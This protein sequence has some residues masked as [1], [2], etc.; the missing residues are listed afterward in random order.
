MA[1]S[2]VQEVPNPEGGAEEGEQKVTPWEAH[3]AEGQA[4]I[5][6]EKLISKLIIWGQP[7]NVKSSLTQ[8]RR[9]LNV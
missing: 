3:A 7:L 9:V 2:G 5:D 8:G 1:E 6:Y 4:T